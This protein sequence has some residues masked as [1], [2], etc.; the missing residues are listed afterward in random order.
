M[1][2]AYINIL[3]MNDAHEI[4]ILPFHMYHSV[5]LSHKIGGSGNCS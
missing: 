4:A 1:L 3:I 2:K 5:S